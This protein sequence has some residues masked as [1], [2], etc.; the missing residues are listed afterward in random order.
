MVTESTL[1]NNTHF[2]NSVFLLN[3]N[4][5]AIFNLFII[6]KIIA[7]KYTKINQNFGY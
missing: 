3:R 7:P 1:G 6:N 5:L 4:R 2:Q